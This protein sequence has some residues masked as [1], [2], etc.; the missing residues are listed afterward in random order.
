MHPRLTH[1]DRANARRDGA[2]GQMAVADDLATAR[3]VGE[4]AATLDPCDDLGFNRLGQHSL[5]S[6]S[7]NF[8]QNVLEADGWKRNDFTGTLGHR[9][10][11]PG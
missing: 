3:I 5:R 1:F 10:R 6:G 4:R 9:W 2:L 8:S 11:A 7:K